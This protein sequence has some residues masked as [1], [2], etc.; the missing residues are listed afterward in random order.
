MARTAAS[1]AKPRRTPPAEDHDPG[2]NELQPPSVGICRWSTLGHRPGDPRDGRPADSEAE[3][4]RGV[5]P[6]RTSLLVWGSSPRR[7]EV[8]RFLGRESLAQPAPLVVAMRGL[9]G[10]NQR[11]V[12]RLARPLFLQ[13][14]RQA[15]EV[16]D[17]F[18]PARSPETHVSKRVGWRRVS[19]RWSGS[20]STGSDSCQTASTDRA[21][22]RR[23]G[24]WS[25]GRA[26][27]SGPTWCGQPS[28]GRQNIGP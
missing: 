5:G 21:Q 23:C 7:G 20:L 11:G 27:G 22:R 26:P 4:R 13:E 18:R 8:Q 16:F 15:N 2:V 1:T 12:T 24:S 9:R 17:L 28:T 3:A 14:R 10:D 25:L 19:V 6:V